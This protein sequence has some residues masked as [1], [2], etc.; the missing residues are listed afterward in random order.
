M[1]EIN[2][3][4]RIAKKYT[5]IMDLIEA[6]SIAGLESVGFKNA[7]DTVMT[8]IALEPAVDLEV[9]QHLVYARHAMDIRHVSSLG[10]FMMF[11]SSDELSKLGVSQ[12]PKEQD[13]VG[14][15]ALRV[16]S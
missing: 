5:A 15:Q 14:L 7:Y 9:P 6:V 4:N 8:N 10:R 12:V 2:S 1:L 13:C 3:L 11:I 16:P